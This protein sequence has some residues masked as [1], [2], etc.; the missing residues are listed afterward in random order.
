MSGAGYSEQA[1]AAWLEWW[2]ARTPEDRAK[3]RA[4]Q[5]QPYQLVTH[6]LHVDVHGIPASVERHA[7]GFTWRLPEFV[8]DDDPDS[9]KETPDG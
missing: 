2:R 6:D 9:E 4:M 8:L 1:R 3:F 7:E 5:D